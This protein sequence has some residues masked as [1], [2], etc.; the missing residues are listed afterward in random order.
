MLVETAHQWALHD[1]DTGAWTEV[2][3]PRSSL[4]PGY[5]L[6]TGEELAVLRPGRSGVYEPDADEWTPGLFID[7]WWGVAW[8]GGEL[9]RYDPSDD[10]LVELTELPG[11]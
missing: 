4:E 10:R 8:T 3:G 6:W 9:A 11:W 2:E 1:L 7:P 5:E